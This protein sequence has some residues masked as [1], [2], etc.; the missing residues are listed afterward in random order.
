MA[1][2]RQAVH[3]TVLEI[4]A[5]RARITSK[6]RSTLVTD[7]AWSSLTRSKKVRKRPSPSTGREA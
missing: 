1:E 5:V 4:S 6:M 7:R 2:P 3:K